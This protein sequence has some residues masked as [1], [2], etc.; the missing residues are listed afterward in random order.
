MH[1][2]QV[3]AAGWCQRCYLGGYHQC[4]THVVL[5]STPWLV[6]PECSSFS[7]SLLS[8]CLHGWS[9]PSC[10]IAYPTLLSG[11]FMISLFLHLI[12]HH[13]EKFP[14][15][16][17]CT[18]GELGRRKRF[19]NRQNRHR[20]MLLSFGRDQ[21][22]K[23]LIREKRPWAVVKSNF[24]G[25]GMDR[26]HACVEPTCVV[27]QWGPSWR[28][29]FGPQPRQGRMASLCRQNTEA[30]SLW[31]WEEGRWP[32]SS[33]GWSPRRPLLQPYGEWVRGEYFLS[34][35]VGLFS[36]RHQVP[37]GRGLYRYRSRDWEPDWME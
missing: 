28:L 11:G 26:G 23:R 6:T 4:P 12:R 14:L 8:L 32:C 17:Q 22:K 15:G 10:F 31:G 36:A 27:K 7:V 35:G 21:R 19:F 13:K 9:P 18:N 29:T 16:L 25:R 33:P 3:P 1:P 20:G 5:A 34:V 2:A 24:A 30:C 37:E